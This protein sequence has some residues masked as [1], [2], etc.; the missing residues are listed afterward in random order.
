MADRFSWEDLR[1][2]LAIAETR[3]LGPAA[4]RLGLDGSTVFRRLGQLESRLAQK[5]FERHRTGYVPT[6]SGA[7]MAALA[8]RMEEEVD[9]LS[10]RLAGGA[11]APAGQIRITTNDTL[12]V[13]VLTPILAKFRRLHPLITL[14]LVL[15]NDS[16]NLSRRDADVAL[17]ATNKPPETLIGR[18][19]A[20]MAWALYGRADGEY[21]A[22]MDEAALRAADWV[23]L[24]DDFS[25]VEAARYARRYALESR[26]VCK[27]NTVLALVEMVQAGIGISPLP[28]FTAHSRP[29]LR[30]LAPPDPSFSTSLWL[31]AHPDLRDAPRIRALLDFLAAEMS[32]RRPL[33]AG[34]ET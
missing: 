13:H 33:F 30:R 25:G 3:K 8:R 12:L 23:V 9:A 5:L 1:L 21:P 2:V 11:P 29:D 27:V 31:L 34:E 6:A 20:T 32:V 10:R 18:R 15:S 19:V 17:R 14:D 26:I 16:L 28:C 22:E 7:D 4:E 24:G